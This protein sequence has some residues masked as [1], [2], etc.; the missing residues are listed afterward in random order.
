MPLLLRELERFDGDAHCHVK[1]IATELSLKSLS[2]RLTL[3]QAMQ[4]IEQ[5]GTH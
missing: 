2:Q 4:T 3:G 5:S 1:K